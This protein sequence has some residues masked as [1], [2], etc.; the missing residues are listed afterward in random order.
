MTSRDLVKSRDRKISRADSKRSRDRRHG[1]AST[2]VV[3]ESFMSDD[4]WV[5]LKGEL[6]SGLNK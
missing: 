1:D 2:S 5:E 3:P 4:S 6:C